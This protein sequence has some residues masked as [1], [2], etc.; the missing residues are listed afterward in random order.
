VLRWT[1]NPEIS[2]VD[3]ENGTLVGAVKVEQNALTF[4]VGANQHQ[5]VS[6]NLLDTSSTQMARGT[7]NESGFASLADIDV[8]TTQGAQDSIGLIDQAI[9][10][11]ATTRGDI[12]AFQRNTLETN[13]STLRAAAE[14][15][16]AAESVVRDV[17][18]ARELADFTRNQ[19]MNQAA[20]AQLAQA[21]ANPQIVL[22]L[23]NY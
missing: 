15:L 22:R 18:M 5:T 17:D 21:N 4:Q 16:T 14:N 1:G 7:K 12:G 19:I 2:D 10:E 13:L 6:V 11:I 8:R 9:G 3:R 23:L 20:A